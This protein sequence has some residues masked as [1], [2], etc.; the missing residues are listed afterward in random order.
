MRRLHDLRPGGGGQFGRE[1]DIAIRRAKDTTITIPDRRL[2]DNEVLTFNLK[3]VGIP[4]GAVT[5]AV[6]GRR[7]ING[8]DAYILEARCKSN[9]FLSAIYNIDDRFVSYMDVEKLYVL[10]QEVY[11]REGNYRKDAVTDFDQLNHKAY[12]KNLVDKSEKIVDIP[13]G[14]E[15]ALTACYYFLMLPLKVGDNIDF[16]VY[17]NEQIYQLIGVVEEKLVIKIPA[18]GVKEAFTV[19]PYISQ[20]GKKLRRERLWLILAAINAACL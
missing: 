17:N 14:V 9:R 15:D 19:R 2:P 4:V 10:R 16:Y 6:N 3:W 13:A 18:L 8:S 12:F 1:K 11:R 5:L 7:N 20:G